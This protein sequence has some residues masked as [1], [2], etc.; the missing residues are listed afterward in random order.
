MKDS[1][2]PSRDT[3]KYLTEN[4]IGN[5]HWEASNW[6]A[7]QDDKYEKETKKN[8]SSVNK[9]KIFL[10]KNVFGWIYHY[11]TT[12][13]WFKHKYQTYDGTDKGIYQIKNNDTIAILSDWGTDTDESN[14]V[15]KQ[16]AKFNPDLS[17]HLGDIYF[18][19]SEEEVKDNFDPK[20]GGWH[21]GKMGSLALPGNHEMYSNGFAYFDILLAKYMKIEQSD[22][23]QQQKAS[24]FCV[25]N[26]HWRIIGL[27]TGYMSV[28]IPIIELIFSP[29]AQLNKKQREWLEK[30][31]RLQDP[32]DKRGIIILSHHQC[33]SAFEKKVFPTS[34]KQIKE[35]MGKNPKT[36][37]WFW[38]HEHR[39]A[40]YEKQTIPDG[41][42]AYVRCIGNGGMP[43][44]NLALPDKNIELAKA[45]KLQYY[46]KRFRKEISNTPIGYNGFITLILDDNK[47]KVQYIDQENTILF[48]EVFSKDS[49]GN[50]F[51][52]SMK[53]LGGFT[54]FGE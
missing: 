16:V 28:G 21:Y 53:D 33:L 45:I 19:G 4:I 5:K 38:G 47:A 31:I 7:S 13:F 43:G 32:T 24:F 26:S 36:V 42:E 20:T 27:D 44:Q 29:K 10:T 3:A 2:E 41:I 49:Q 48:E 8:K 22:I 40:I 50:V 54:K 34:A 46:D 1:K 15:T 12:R 9:I 23:W 17:L 6:Y 14:G 52:E 30:V 11:L 37:A 18:V 39:T 35:I 25:E 51:Q